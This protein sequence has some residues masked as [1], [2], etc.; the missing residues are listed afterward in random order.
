[1]EILTSKHRQAVID[2]ELETITAQ[3]PVARFDEVT[4]DLYP[5]GGQAKR[6]IKAWI[7]KKAS[8]EGLYMLLLCDRDNILQFKPQDEVRVGGSSLFGI[9]DIKRL[10]QDYAE[11]IGPH[12]DILMKPRSKEETETHGEG[13]ASESEH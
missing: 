1:M 11:N 7:H 5:A 2:F 12:H 6:G 8:R 10:C 4:V 13:D 3:H 9:S